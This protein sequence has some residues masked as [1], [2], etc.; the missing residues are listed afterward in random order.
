MTKKRK[1]PQAATALLSALADAT[2]G[3]W[4]QPQAVSDLDVAFPAN[5]IGK[6]L[7]EMAEI[8]KEFHSSAHPWCSV[9]SGLFFRGGTL[10]PTLEGIDRKNAARHLKAVLG[11]FEPKHEHK[12][13]GA[14]YLMSLWFQLP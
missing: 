2:A 7:P 4:E 14:A 5:I 6:L 1:K 12:E 3:K 9:V 10:P 13:A 8:P 11:S